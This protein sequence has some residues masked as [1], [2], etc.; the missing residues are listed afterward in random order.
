M[1]K[2]IDIIDYKPVNAGVIDY[3]PNN[4]SFNLDFSNQVYEQTLSAGMYMGI[5]PFTY[6]ETIT[7]NSPFSP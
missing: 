5:P 4:N 1:P 3:K 2:N 7:I 6:P